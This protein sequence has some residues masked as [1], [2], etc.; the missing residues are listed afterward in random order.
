MVQRAFC[1]ALPAAL[2]PAAG[3]YLEIFGRKNNLRNFWVTVGNE[4]GAGCTAGWSKKGLIGKRDRPRVPQHSWC[5]L[6][7]G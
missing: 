7:S 4:V 2:P 1:F 3:R 5:G 6:S